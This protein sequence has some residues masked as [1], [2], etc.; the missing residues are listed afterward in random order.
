MQLEYILVFY[1]SLFHVKGDV[2]E[3]ITLVF[4]FFFL[5]D[6]ILTRAIEDL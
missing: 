6:R 1:I 3:R 2:Y 4:F 5:S